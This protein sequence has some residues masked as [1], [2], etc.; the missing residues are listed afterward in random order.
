MVKATKAK[1]WGA[2]VITRQWIGIEAA[3]VE[4]AIHRL[5]RLSGERQDVIEA[6]IQAWVSEHTGSW[7]DCIAVLEER[8]NAGYPV[9]WTVRPPVPLQEVQP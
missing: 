5:Q 7:R 8:L 3:A 2:T 6:Y 9:D 4:L 1:C